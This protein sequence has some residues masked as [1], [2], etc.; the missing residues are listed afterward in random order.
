MRPPRSRATGG[1]PGASST[2]GPTA[3]PAT[4]SDAGAQ[5]QDKV[6]QYLYNC[7]EYLE[8]IFAAF[9]AGLVPV[10]TNYR[11]VD[12]ELVYLWDNADAVAVVFHGTFTDRIERLRDRLPGVRHWLW[13]DDGSGPR[14]GLGR[15]L[16]G[17]RGHDHR[18]GHRPLGPR[19]RRHPHDL[20]RRHHRH[21]QGRD[22]APGRPDRRHVRHRQ[23]TAGRGPGEGRRRGGRGRAHGAPGRPGAAGLPAHARHRL[24]HGQHLPDPGRLGGHP[25]GPPPRLDRAAR[26]HRAGGGAVR[27]RSWATPSPSP[28]WPRSTPG[29]GTWDLSSLL[30]ITSS[31]VM[32][33]EPSKQGLLGAQPQHDAGRRVLVLGG[34]RHGPVGLRRRR[35]REARPTSP[36]GASAT[37]ITDDGRAVEPGS[38]ETAGW[39][40]PAAPRS[41]TT[42][43]RR[44]RPPPSSPSTACATR[45]PATTPR[46][47]PTASITLL[48]RGSVCINTGGEKVFPEEVEEVLKTHDTVRDAVVV[49][50]PDDKFG[51]AITAVVEPAAG[52]SLDGGELIAHVKGHL[53]HYKAPK[54]RAGDRHHRPGPQRQGRLQAHEAVRAGHAGF[55][56]G[57]AAVGVRFVPA[58]TRR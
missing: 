45:C 20:H 38:G 27:S 22:V 50:V 17:G 52:T 48:G 25:G 44:S 37:V 11:Y 58:V 9:K 40:S 32:W 28:C 30:L 43:T 56:T 49:G 4:C 15:G 36:S 47:R 55:L 10:N 54:R 53:A 35:G 5:H 3:S 39:P 29:P 8:S 1:P 34:H 33:S 7:P 19:R 57:P 12:D 6:A 13:V 26:H 16:R 31:G 51:E 18:A 14:P 21:A 23:P 42:R 2:P 41:G 46:S 24:V